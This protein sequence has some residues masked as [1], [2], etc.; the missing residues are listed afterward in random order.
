MDRLSLF[1]KRWWCWTMAIIAIIIMLSWHW[2]N[3]YCCIMLSHWR[4]W[5]CRR[6]S[7]WNGFVYD[8]KDIRLSRVSKSVYV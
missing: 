3:T 8:F 4:H 1:K 5:T 6:Y 7:C 2:R